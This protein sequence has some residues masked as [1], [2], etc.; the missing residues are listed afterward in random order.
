MFIK[1]IDKNIVNIKIIDL[2]FF[3]FPIIDEISFFIW[4][5]IKITIKFVFSLFKKNLG[6][7]IIGIVKRIQFVLITELDGS[8]IENRFVIIFIKYFCLL[9]F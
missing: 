3:E 4:F 2:Y 6:I 7:K 1:K 8:N 9:I 5:F